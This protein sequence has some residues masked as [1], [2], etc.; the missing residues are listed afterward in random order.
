MEKYRIIRTIGKGSFGS[1]LV[2]Q[3]T[4]TAVS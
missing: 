2:V 1:A 3:H 4:R